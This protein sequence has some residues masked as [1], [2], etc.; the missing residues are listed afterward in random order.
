MA[1]QTKRQQS[2]QGGKWCSRPKR[3]AIYL[4]DGLCCVWCGASVE[5]GAQLSLDHLKPH[6]A[7]GGNESTN[8]V[9][10]CKRCNSS[11]GDRAVAVFA[12]AVAAYLNHGRE[13]GDILKHVRNCARRQVDTK[14]AAELIQ[15]RGSYAAALTQKEA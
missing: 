9:T 6:V 5:D 8:L 2:W 4:R 11:R 12:R 1:K 7:G 3:L 14:A 10:A 13:A 15:R